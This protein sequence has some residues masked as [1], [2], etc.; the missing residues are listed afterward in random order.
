M[1]DKATWETH[2]WLRWWPV[3]SWLALLWVLLNSAWV[4]D[5]A[6]ISF[7]TVD[8]LVQGHGAVFNPGERVQA[9][10][11]PLWML[12]HV[13]FYALT[14]DIYLVTILLSLGLSLGAAAGL[15]RTID[16]R[17]A[18]GLA[19][20]CFVF[21]KALTDYASS[22]L[23]NPLTHVLLVLFAW[24][25]LEKRTHPR[26]IFH[27]SLLFALLFVNRMDGILLLLPA[28]AWRSWELRSW[29]TMRLLAWG[30]LPIL[31]WEAFSIVY[32]GFPF[33]NTAYAK[34]GTGIS[35]T[36]LFYTGLSYWHDSL[37]RDL[38]TLPLAGL[39]VGI[40][41]W[42][43]RCRPLA[44]GVLL[45]LLYTLRIGG[46]FMSGRFLSAP[47]FLAALVLLYSLRDSVWAGRLLLQGVAVLLAVELLLWGLG[48]DGDTQPPVIGDTGVADERAY[49]EPGTGLRHVLEGRQMPDFKWVAAGQ[50][51]A[52]HPERVHVVYNLGFL[53]FY[54]GP[55]H[56]LIDRYGL[57]DP[58]LARLPCLEAPDRRP[59]HYERVLPEGYL[60]SVRQDT[61]A[62]ADPALH[63]L[64]GDLCLLTRGPLW[65]RARWAAIWR[66][67]TEQ[68]A[69]L[70]SYATPVA[71]RHIRGVPDL[72]VWTLY[73]HKGLRILPGNAPPT[74]LQFTVKGDCQLAL[75]AH[76]HNGSI[77]SK[78][79]TLA[80]GDTA[81]AL[82]VAPWPSDV[83]S[84]S[85]YPI[86]ECG[87]VELHLLPISVH[88]GG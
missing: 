75:S 54:G 25:L 53:G 22:G 28:L 16:T 67:L 88:A 13:P 8:N 81:R 47:Y 12:L 30:A 60:R 86:G 6:Y 80:A 23:E 35:G 14:G 79:I 84:L 74:E 63:T 76:H 56:F 15:A 37:D 50:R 87:G 55:A 31:A 71:A 7:R 77:R 43:R 51:L 26:Q 59:G 68:P 49:Y 58:L 19:P 41:L 4:C 72:G 2:P 57:S 36:A 70:R 21:S 38:L 65:T 5:D 62:L 78:W 1:T 17:L 39:G 29:R 73:P 46:D 27:L 11:H 34:L 42:N 48:A 83:D 3:L 24:V 9:F 66:Q 85:L 82:Q 20:L 52:A 64:Y 44:L 40:G 69:D 61:N 32:Y 33:P 45:Y 18:W 10:T